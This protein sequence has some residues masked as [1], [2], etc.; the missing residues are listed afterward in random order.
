MNLSAVLSLLAWVLLLLSPTQTK[1]A[2]LLW[3]ILCLWG[4]ALAFRHPQQYPTPTR[5]AALRWFAA[6][7]ITLVSWLSM[8][9][10]WNE[11]CCKPSA[12]VSAGLRLWLGALAA[13]LW[14]K[15]W[16]PMPKWQN[17]INHGLAW[18]CISSLVIAI[19][20]TRGELPS[21]PIPWS[22]AVAMMISL[23]LPQALDATED[24]QQRRWWLIC[25]A[26]GLAAVLLSQSR[27]TYLVIG[28][29]I[30]LVVTSPHS[31]HVRVQPIKI[32]AGCAWV[33]IA[34]GLTSAM[35]SDPL[36][37]REGWNDWNASRHSES[38]NTSLGALLVLYE[39]AV[40]TIAASPWVGIGSHERLNRIHTLG[41]NLPPEEATKLSHAREQGHVHNGYLHHAMDGG[42]V[43][44]IGFLASIGG[45]IYAA[46]AWRHSNPMAQRQM[47]GLAFVH[48][49]TSLS[50]VN[51]AH[52]YYVV[53]L[54]MCVMLVII[55]ASADDTHH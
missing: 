38:Q 48:A 47:L 24:A 45:L 1:L 52:N 53:M 21:Y 43:S 27:G 55:Q 13:F 46:R 54:S 51:L 50:N 34:M 12:E 16:R 29:M 2:G 22:A 30:Y 36:R 7:N 49:T 17:R 31:M 42:I 5:Q 15:H 41:Q 11:P 25:C 23:L 35:P 39:L 19:V 4:Y 14:A 33:A 9:F 3:V 32:A 10:Y 37:I 26:L 8:S 6:A 18:A 40:N 28:W 44:L 20:M